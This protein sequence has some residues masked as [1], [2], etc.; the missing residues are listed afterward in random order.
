VTT[1]DFTIE[2]FVRVDQAMLDVKKHPLSKLYPSEAVTIGILYALRS[3]SFRSFDRWLHR[4]L[5]PLFPHLPER[6]R[7]YR[8]LC[9][10]RRWTDRFLAQPT[11]FGVLDGYGIEMLHPRRLGW[12]KNQWAGIGKSNGRWIAGAKLGL[13][14]NNQGQVVN[15]DV[16]PANMS[17]LEFLPLAHALQEKSILLADQGFLLSKKAKKQYLVRKKGR[18]RPQNLLIC[19]K[20]Q[21]PARRLVETVFALFTQ[22]L[23]LKHFTQR[24]RSGVA[25]HI[26]F[27]VAAYNICS[28]W[29]GTV[30]LHLAQFAL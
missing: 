13:S 1:Q 19:K 7:L 4:E 29:F 30:D 24:Q 3:G 22:V 2:V 16:A 27:A 9:S 21:W 17:D 28:N 8:I 15:W 18:V 23:H 5:A 11:F 14:I 25:M 10:L 12:T 6:T 20:G 26:A